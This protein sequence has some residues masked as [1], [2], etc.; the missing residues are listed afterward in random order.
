MVLPMQS[1]PRAAIIG[2]TGFLGR[3]LPALL[4]ERGMAVTGISRGHRGGIPGVDLWQT[5]DRMDFSGH[6]V[7][8]NLA[9]EPINRRWTPA[10]KRK[11]HDS[12]VGL[13]R[14][15][16][17]AIAR[18]PEET[19]PQILINASAIGIYGN[20]GDEILDD[21][22]SP[23]TGYLAAL[24]RDWEDAALATA[25]PGLRV[26]CLRTGVVLGKGGGPWQ[27]L[28][29]V[30]KCGIGGPL[31]SGNQWMSW[32]HVDDLRAA[33]VHA[34]FSGNLTGPL[35][36]TAPHPERNRTL[37]CK[38]AAALHRP[39]FFRVPAFALRLVLGEFGGV[40]LDSQR[41]NPTALL[42]DG[43]HFRHPTLESALAALVR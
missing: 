14:R 38:I 3:G 29:K 6:D 40:L 33:L 16:V 35:N 15:V 28:E 41:V 5:P 19:R 17:E 9:G 8:I 34:V 13:T 22:A 11:F 25:P 42:N 27:Q 21:T 31:G 2:V 30:F 1:H 10:A 20:R 32:I 4:A 12:R 24:C 18:V 43:F 26:V 39:A 37:T 7:V 36:A 23:G